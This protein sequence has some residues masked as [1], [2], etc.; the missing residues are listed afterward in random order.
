MGI[1]NDISYEDKDNIKRD[2]SPSNTMLRS[3]PWLRA[4]VSRIAYLNALLSAGVLFNTLA[5]KKQVRQH[6]KNEKGFH[7]ET[8]SI[9][10]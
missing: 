2:S 1:R 6:S 10:F 9:I 5:S 4:S 7:T 3:R 8:N